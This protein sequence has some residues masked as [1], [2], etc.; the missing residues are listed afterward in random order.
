MSYMLCHEAPPSVPQPA[1]FFA[2]LLSLPEFGHIVES[3]VR[4][5]WLYR[6][7][8]EVKAGR[9]VLGAVHEP[10]VTGRL[11]EVFSWMLQDKFGGSDEDVPIKFLVIIDYE[12]WAEADHRARE[13]LIYHEACHIR[14]ALGK[15]GEQRFDKE[16]GLPVLCLVGHDVEE[17][18]AVVRRYGAWS[19]DLQAF[20]SAAAD[21]D[22]SPA[23]PLPG[24]SAPRIKGDP[25]W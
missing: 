20:I 5:E 2:R 1:E 17:F 16:T 12:Y 10:N 22:E 15:D 14:P 21:G 24:P 11:R 13:I 4:I 9:Q 18:S 19:D 7:H 23:E 8:P 3:E 6:T 25:P